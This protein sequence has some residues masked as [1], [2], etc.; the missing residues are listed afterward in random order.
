M[1]KGYYFI[2][3]PDLSH[4]GI[5]SDVRNALRAKVKVIQYR[6]KCASARQMFEE[7]RKLRKICRNVKFLINDRVDIA[8]SVNADGVHLGKDDLSYAVARKILGRKK[9]IGLTVH[10]VKDAIEAQRAGADYIGVSAIFATAT[11]IDAGR[12]VGTSL[13]K[14]IRKHVTIP[15]V[16]IGGINLSNAKQVIQAG[17]DAVCAISAVVSKPDVRKEIEEF[18]RLFK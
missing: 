3:D 11:K 9:I 5:F 2:T 15:I 14:E 8:L 13:I 7:A 17:A 12:P 4:A 18:Q 1:L 16:A 10:T 6:N